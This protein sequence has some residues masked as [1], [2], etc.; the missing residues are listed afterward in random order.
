MIDISSTLLDIANR[1]AQSVVD[2]IKSTLDSGDYPHGDADRGYTSIQNSI[3]I[4]EPQQ[5]AGS[6]SV[7]IHIGGDSA[8]YAGAFEYGSGLHKE[9][10][11]AD[12]Y[13]IA[14]VKASVLAFPFTITYMPRAG[15]LVGVAGIG[16]YQ[17]VWTMFV[18]NDH[19]QLSGTMFWNYVNHPGIESKPYIRPT[20]PTTLIK[21]REL[22]RKKISA[23]AIL[24]A[25]SEVIE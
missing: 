12:T 17:K 5:S 10:G 22:Y 4:D 1:I 25:V 11:H 19:G 16:D 8:P 21:M 13:V 24:G 23:Q 6:V 3:S 7:D 9:F 20:L 2:D 15:K 18:N 14:P